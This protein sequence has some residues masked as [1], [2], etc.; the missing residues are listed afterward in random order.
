MTHPTPR[1]LTRR[2]FL[3]TSL[4]AAATIGLAAC[5][6]GSTNVPGQQQSAPAGDGGAAGYDGPKVD[7]KFWNGFTGGDGAFMKKLVDE[8]NTSHPNIAISVQTMQWA[9]YYA[10]L[11][12]DSLLRAS[13][14]TAEALA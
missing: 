2:G 10:K 13:A 1:A 12:Q 7:L 5:G 11:L 9:D 14:D 8:F 4:G 6:G 3:A